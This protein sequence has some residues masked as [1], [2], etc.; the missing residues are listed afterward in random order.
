MTPFSASSRNA[1]VTAGLIQS[2]RSASFAQPAH[3]TLSH[4]AAADHNYRRVAQL[5]E[6]DRIGVKG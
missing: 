4:R 2:H 5:R 6:R 3:L 1:G